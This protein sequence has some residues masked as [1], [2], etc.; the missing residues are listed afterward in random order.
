MFG[1]AKKIHIIEE[2]L[3]IE[4]AHI[5]QEVENILLSHSAKSGEV[6]KFASFA[7]SLTDVEVDELENI[8]TE[9]CEK[10]NTNDWK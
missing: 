3:K 10:I 1:E 5:L 6:K 4:D 8:I 7:G 9:G 2:L